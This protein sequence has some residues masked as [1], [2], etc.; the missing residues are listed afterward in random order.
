MPEADKERNK[1]LMSLPGYIVLI[2]KPDDPCTWYG[3]VERSFDLE[4]QAWRTQ[5]FWSSNKSYSNLGTGPHV[6]DGLK[7]AKNSMKYWSDKYPM[8]TFYIYDARDDKKLPVVID[9]DK[10][11]DAEQIDTT[12]LSGIKNKF[13]GRNLYIYPKGQ[14]PGFD[15]VVHPVVKDVQEGKQEETDDRFR[16]REI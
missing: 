13:D 5:F 10:W 2:R 8:W 9:W 15:V 6:I 7:D 14:I 11:L 1:I 3:P 12:K 16:E 4:I